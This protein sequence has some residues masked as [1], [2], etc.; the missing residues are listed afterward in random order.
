M[1][2]AADENF[3]NDVLRGVRLRLPEVDIVRVQDSQ[4]AAADDP[5][6]LEWAAQEN[7]IILTHDVKTMTKYAYER[8]RNGLPMPGVVEINSYVDI[9]QAIEALVLFIEC[10]IEGEW[11]GQV[12]FLPL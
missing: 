5:T 6:V 2:F 12:I 9:G 1:R 7:R 3:N 4:V 10:S 8:V 11:E